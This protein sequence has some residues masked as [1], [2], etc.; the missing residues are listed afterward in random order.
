MQEVSNM[1]ESE[2]NKF[3]F[4][5]SPNAKRFFAFL[6]QITKTQQWTYPEIC[7]ESQSVKHPPAKVNYPWSNAYQCIH[8]PG[9]HG[10]RKTPLPWLALSLTAAFEDRTNMGTQAQREGG[11]GGWEGGFTLTQQAGKIK[12]TACRPPSHP[13]TLLSLLL[14]DLWPHLWRGW[15]KWKEWNS[16]GRAVLGQLEES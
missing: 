9:Q 16:R 2:N 8:M 10:K 4:Y 11:W 13:L 1:H 5:F 12:D 7:S 14:V 15:D 3:L 6:D